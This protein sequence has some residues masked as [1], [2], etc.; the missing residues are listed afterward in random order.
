M[1][2]IVF[3]DGKE[4][5]EET[6]RKIVEIDNAVPSEFDPEW[7]PQEPEHQARLKQFQEL[8]DRDFFEVAF[9]EKE[10]I[11]FHV[12]LGKRG[13]KMNLGVISTLWV[14][15]VYRGQGIAKQ[16]K[17][18][19]LDWARASKLQYLQTSTHS[20]NER[21]MEINLK[22]GFVPYSVTLKYKL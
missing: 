20:N 22:S 8:S 1:H 17:Q 18:K 7:Q 10:I 19:G 11:G 3:K 13:P 2:S 14:H 21:M 12:I 5:S 6:L 9:S 16:L 4:L 15:P